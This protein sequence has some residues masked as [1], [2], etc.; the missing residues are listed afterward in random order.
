M[1]HVLDASATLAVIFEETGADA[2]ALALR[3]GAAMS[4]VNAAEVSARLHQDRWTDPE[5]ALAF[6]ELGI[7]LLPFGPETA[8][9]SGKYR[10]ATT[11]LG[12]GLGDRACLATAC[13]EQCPALTADQSWRQLELV[14]V[15]IRCIR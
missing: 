3:S 15:E 13:L 7:E 8:M 5:V 6:E 1:K 9:L 10:N 12:L 14:G 11:H 4:T 2:V